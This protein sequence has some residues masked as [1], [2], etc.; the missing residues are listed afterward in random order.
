MCVCSFPYID[1]LH[2]NA[3]PLAETSNWLSCLGPPR[4]ELSKARR[5]VLSREH[6]NCC[7]SIPDTLNR[8]VLVSPVMASRSVVAE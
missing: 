5:R 4:V 3:V 2:Q 8:K 1:I 6:S 7:T